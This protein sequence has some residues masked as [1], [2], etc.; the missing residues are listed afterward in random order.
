MP[1]KSAYV[2]ANSH[3]FGIR[4]ICIAP[5]EKMCISKN[6]SIATYVIGLAGAIAA[7]ATRQYDVGVLALVVVQIQLLEI[8]LWDALNTGNEKKNRLLT[9]LIHKALLAQAIA[10]GIGIVIQ[11]ATDAKAV[12]NDTSNLTARDFAPFIAGVILVGIIWFIEPY[13]NKL[14]NITGQKINYG[15]NGNYWYIG[16]SIFMLIIS[17]VYMRRITASLFSL[18]LVASFALSFVITNSSSATVGSLWC[19]LA[20]V[21]TPL[22][23]GVNYYMRKKEDEAEKALQNSS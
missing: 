14:S 3:V 13:R 9:N 7:L 1:Y 11:R 20:A 19:L 22:F 15:F 23:V 21:M 4:R 12:S 18:Y 17:W 5:Y 10:L 16:I 8:F 6:V 2:S